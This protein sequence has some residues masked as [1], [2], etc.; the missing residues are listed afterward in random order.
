LANR[1]V[2]AG[3]INDIFALAG[4]YQ[5]GPGIDLGVGIDYTHYQTAVSNAV[6]V[7]GTPYNGLALMAGIGIGF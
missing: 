2:N 1:E 5:L 7:S 4:D 3:A 6:N